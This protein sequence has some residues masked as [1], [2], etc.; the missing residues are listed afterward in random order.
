MKVTLKPSWELTT[1]HPASSYGQPVLVNR[2]SGEAFG[3]GDILTPYPSWGMMPASGAVERMA[4]NK[5]FTDEERA[6]VSRFVDF[7]K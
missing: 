2:G 4:S 6:F 3:P 7:G 1:D 5:K